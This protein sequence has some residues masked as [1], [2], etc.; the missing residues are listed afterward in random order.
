MSDLDW[1][2]DEQLAELRE[3]YCDAANWR[4]AVT[5]ALDPDAP[6]DISRGRALDLI[7]RLKREKMDG[8][9]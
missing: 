5:H 8:Q 4:A 1:M 3:E 6:G 7:E 9:T 2:T